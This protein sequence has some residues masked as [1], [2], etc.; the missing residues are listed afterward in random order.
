MGGNSKLMFDEIMDNLEPMYRAAV[1]RNL[2][3]G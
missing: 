3:C 2:K 1:K